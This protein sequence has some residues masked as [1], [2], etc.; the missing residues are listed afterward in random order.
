[1]INANDLPKTHLSPPPTLYLSSFWLFL[2]CC[3]RRKIE[4]QFPLSE[5]ACLT[6]H[7]SSNPRHLCTYRLCIRPRQRRTDLI[8]SLDHMETGVPYFLLPPLIYPPSHF[9]PSLFTSSLY[10]HSPPNS[11]SLISHYFWFLHFPELYFSPMPSFHFSWRG[12]GML[13][14]VEYFE[15]M[16]SWG[17]HWEDHGFFLIE[18]SSFLKFCYP[19]NPQ[20]EGIFLFSKA[21]L[22]YH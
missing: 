13:Q 19:I 18:R 10:H 11:L 9:H 3:S 15:C 5:M 6:P 22:F 20:V 1:M 8:Q 17:P 4:E 21:L 14:P 2:L 7:L 12:S 16:N